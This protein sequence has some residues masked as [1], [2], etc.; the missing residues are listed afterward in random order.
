M[1]VL[2]ELAL[3]IIGVLGYAITGPLDRRRI[4]SFLYHRGH[5]LR[6]IRWSPLSAGWFSRWHERFNAVEFEDSDGKRHSVSCRT[7]R[8]AG[9]VVD[10]EEG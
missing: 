1:Y 10:E 4:A 6:S 3:S 5:Y 2:I 7:S 9:V 8:S